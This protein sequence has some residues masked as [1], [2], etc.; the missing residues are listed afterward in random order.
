MDYISTKG[1]TRAEWLEARRQGIGGSD[2]SAIMEQNPWSSPLMV[3][4]DKRG[5][6]PD[7]EETEAMRQ[8]TDC[9][10]V[11]AKRFER[12]TGLKVKRCNK[13]FSHPDYPWMKANI[14]RQL[15]GTDGFVGLEAKTTSPFAKTD[16]EGGNIPPNYFWQCQH[17]M[18]VTDAQE[19][20]LA[21]MVF[22]TSFHIFRI[23]RDENAITQLIEAERIFWHDHVL[24]GEPPYPSG[25]NGE[26]DAIEGMYATAR[27]DKAAN[28]DDMRQ[29]LERLALYEKDAK[30]LKEKMEA[31]KNALKL[32][33]GMC[34]N[35]ACGRWTVTWKDETRTTIDSKRLKAEAPETFAMYSKTS[36]TRPLKIKEV[37]YGS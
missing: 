22:S 9:E 11:V 2:A 14:D 19:W 23:V 7:K 36:T 33:M 8:G 30:L 24:A 4:M 10:E 20:Y 16:F 5:I 17:Y 3:Y 26:A 12:E 27:Y 37:A 29:E 15:V 28:I 25:I 34:T 35:A 1:M 6:A 18:A 13:L 21:V 31:I 32:R